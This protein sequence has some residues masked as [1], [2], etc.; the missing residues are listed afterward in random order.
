MVESKNEID[1]LCSMLS[2]CN[3]V[4]NPREWWMDSSATRH[5][6]EN[7]ELF[8]A[9]DLAQSEEKIYMRNSAT[10][11]VEGMGKI[12]LK[13]MSGKVLTLNKILYMSKLGKNLIS[14]SFLNMNGF[15]FVF[16]F[17][18]I[19]PSKE[20]YLGKGYLTEGLFK[21]NVMIV[22][23]NKSFVSSYLLEYN[24]LWHEKLGHVN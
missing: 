19:L 2:E 18:K 16:A 24:D 11:K 4:E 6:C 10:V 5:I 9:F 17:D 20:V 8:A 12:C 22:E 3:I 14:V 23:I 15:K 13:L 21:M 1:D 7:K